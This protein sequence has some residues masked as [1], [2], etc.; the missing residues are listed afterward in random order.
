MVNVGILMMLNDVVLLVEDSYWLP[1]TKVNAKWMGPVTLV[2]MAH[3]G[4]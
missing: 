3:N 1:N 4:P 2:T